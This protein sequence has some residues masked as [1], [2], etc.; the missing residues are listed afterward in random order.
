MSFKD[1][2]T[3]REGYLNELEIEIR[4]DPVNRWDPDKIFQHI[5]RIDELKAWKEQP[6]H[7]RQPGPIMMG[8]HITNKCNEDCP[9]CSGWREKIGANLSLP[10]PIARIYLDEFAMMGGKALLFSGGGEPWMHKAATD[11]LEYARFLDIE[12]AVISN[13]TRFTDF[14][15]TV[16]AEECSWVRLSLD[17]GS[18][19][20]RKISHGVDLWDKLMKNMDRL[21]KRRSPKC[22]LGA[23]MLVDKRTISDCEKFLKIVKDKGFDYAQ[24][25]PYQ[26]LGNEWFDIDT[27]QYLNGLVEKYSD[28]TFQVVNSG[29]R[30]M[31]DKFYR[32]YDYCWGAHFRFDV[33][34]NQ[35][36]Y[37]CCHVSGDSKNAHGKVEK[38]G[39][40]IKI[41]QKKSMK[42]INVR[43]CLPYCIY[44][45]M[46]TC[47]QQCMKEVPH[48]NWL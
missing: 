40:F 12:T 30:K 48:K 38:E 22:T 9:D 47:L 16:I 15:C 14:D 41:W 5:D 3:R 26:Y 37:P 39:D 10:Y 27:W 46:N 1:S 6:D 13:G 18:R 8:F 17:A 28:N 42:K 24:F 7:R 25:R 44:H 35:M 36:C 29:W 33:N 4:K 11:I 34:A 43:K 2:D 20:M 31:E 45:R 19:E 21:A 23:G 32:S